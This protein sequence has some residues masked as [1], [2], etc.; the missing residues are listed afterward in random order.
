MKIKQKDLN[1][2][3]SISLISVTLIAVLSPVLKQHGSFN[4]SITVDE[5]GKSTQRPDLINV[6]PDAMLP[7]GFLMNGRC[8]LNHKVE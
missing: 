7:P 8:S 5:H 6:L 1:L 3:G 4:C 2:T